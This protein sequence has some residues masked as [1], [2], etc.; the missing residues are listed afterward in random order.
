MP[1]GLID[2]GGGDTTTEIFVVANLQQYAVEM[3]C[4]NG[5][6]RLA[7]NTNNKLEGCIVWNDT[8]QYSPEAVRYPCTSCLL[9]AFDDA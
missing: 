3:Q 6:R 1:R 4:R 9:T 7:V 5:N 8:I 2:D